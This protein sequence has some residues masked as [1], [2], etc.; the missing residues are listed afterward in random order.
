[1]RRFVLFVAVVLVLA[2]WTG[3]AWAQYGFGFGH[4]SDPNAEIEAA[5]NQ[6]KQQLQKYSKPSGSGAR[7]SAGR[8]AIG[9]GFRDRY[10]RMDLA[11]HAVAGY[12]MVRGDL[13]TIHASR[14]KANGSRRSFTPPRS[15]N[16][17]R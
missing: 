4:S 9:G 10:G 1:M 12:P 14:G 8:S 13:D 16:R 2:S 11:G 6:A 5:R 15:G 3:P 7:G 17:R